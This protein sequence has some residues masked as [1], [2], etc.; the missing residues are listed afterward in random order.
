VSSPLEVLFL[1]FL[2][3]VILTGIHAYLGIHVISRKVIFVDIA[4]AQIAALGGTVAFLLGYDPRSEGAYFFSLAF[5]VLAAIVFALTR[6]RHE[7]VPQEAVIGLTYATASAAAILLADISPHG[8]EHLHDLLAGSIVWVTPQQIAKTAILYS[9]LGLFHIVFRK[10]F[11]QISLHPEEAYR[12]GVRVRLWDFLFYLSFGVVITSSV[13]IAGVLLV[14]CYL[15]APS[16]FAVMFFDSLRPRLITGWTMGT[17]VSAVGLYFSYDRPSGPTIMVVFAIALLLGGLARSLWPLA[18]PAVPL[19]ATA[20]VMVVLTCAAGALQAHHAATPEP[21]EAA[22]AAEAAITRSG[23]DTAPPQG[24]HGEAHE[25]ATGIGGQRT[26]LHDEHPEVRARAVAELARSGDPRVLHDLV[27]ALADQ[28]A[29]VREAAAAAV[30]QMGNRSAIPALRQHLGHKDEDP[31]VRL[32]MAESLAALGERDGLQALLDLAATGDGGLLR[33]EAL[34]T[35]SKFASLTPPV[36][37]PAGD[38]ARKR[39][40][41][42]R[43]WWDRNGARLHF[44]PQTRTFH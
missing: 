14:F 22:A 31:W 23:R 3:C 27:D 43:A 19:A 44:D 18:R 28:D 37:D 24:P 41:A 42:L 2:A 33:L 4:L 25:V 36:D 40:G 8:A 6:T 26:A 7:R 10:R 5:A 13:Q 32:R 16:I 12:Q 9:L 21:G 29:G 34:N 11:L 39:L 17:L 35:L 30:G 1:P 15:V 20:T 38:A